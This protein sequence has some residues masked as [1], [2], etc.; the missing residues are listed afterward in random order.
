M[1]NLVWNQEPRFTA[2]GEAGKYY[3]VGPMMGGGGGTGT[4]HQFSAMVTYLDD[5]GEM[6]TEPVGN[7]IFETFQAAQKA[8][9][10]LHDK[11]GR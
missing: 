5:N 1:A 11:S 10:D 6:R 3:R 2:K 9:Q 8:C 7:G 4:Q